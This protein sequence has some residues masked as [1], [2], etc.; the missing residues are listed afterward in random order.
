[1]PHDSRVAQEFAVV[2]AE[3]TWLALGH[4]QHAE[5]SLFSMRMGAATIARSPP[6]ASRAAKGE[7]GTSSPDS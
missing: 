7:R 2:G 4:E 6:T 3:G 1:V 5:T